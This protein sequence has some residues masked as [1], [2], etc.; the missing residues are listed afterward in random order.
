MRKT[1][2]WLGLC[3]ALALLP[4]SVLP[5]LAAPASIPAIPPVQVAQ[6]GQVSGEITDSSGGRLPAATVTLTSVERGFSRTT[7]TD[8]TGRFLF[9]LVSLGTYDITV[10]LPGFQSKRIT[11]NLV[12]A[13]K[14]TVVSTSLSVAAVAETTTVVGD[15]P[16]V[17]A[18]NQTQQTRLRS[19]EFQRLPVGRSYQTLIGQVA[20]VVGTGNVNAHGALT[21]NNQFMSDGVNTSDTVTGGFATNL[22]F[23]SIA[24]VVVRTAG[25]PAE[26]GRSTGAYVDVITK[27]GT[28][29][30]SGSFKTIAINDAWDEPNS[31][32]SE[33]ASADCTF[34]SL[35]RTK[36]DK[37]NKTYS[38]TVG[39]PL[40]VNRAWFFGA[41]EDSRSTTPETQLNARPGIT[42]ENFQQV[43]KILYPNIRGT[44]QLSPGQSV[45]VKYASD[46]FTGI[47]RN[48]Y[49]TRPAEREALTAQ[50]QGGYAV[51]G[52]YTVVLGNQ[53]TA[54]ATA[55]FQAN[56]ITVVPF[57]RTTLD[58]G[59]PYYDLNDNRVY[60]G[61]TFDGYVKRPRTQIGAATTYITNLRGQAHSF[62]IGVDAQYLKSENA[63]RFPNNQVF[64][65]YDFDP[66]ARRFALNDSR[67]DYD[68]APSRSDG[69]QVAVYARDRFQLGARASVELGVRVER[70][71]GKSDVGVPTVDTTDIAPRISASYALTRDSK[72]LVQASYGRFYDGVLQSYSDT[73]ANV[74]Q[75]ENY[76]TYIWNGTDYVFS[77]RSETGANTFAPDTSVTP[78]HM[79]EFTVGVERQFGRTLGT[80]VRYIQ[81]EWNNFIDDVRAFNED[82]TLNRTVRNVDSAS[83]SYKGVE[84]T[85][86]KRFSSRW[87]AAGSY[88]YSETRGNHVDTGDN[89][90]PLEDYTEAICSQTVDPG[91]FGGGTFPCRE[92]QAN[93]GGRPSFDRPHLIKFSGS[94]AREVG[95]VNLVAGLVGS[96]TSK[97]TYQ[98]TRT[99]DVLSPVTGEQFA[100]IAYWYEP[101]GTQRIPGLVDVVDLNLEAA[102]RGPKTSQIG[103][104][105]ET[106]NLFN[107]EEKINVSNTT[108]CESTATTACATAV[109]NFGTATSRGA[110]QAPRT[111][112]A[113]LVVRY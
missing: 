72:T 105:F 59:A 83:R 13:Q 32:K 21:A 6:V 18:T 80:G 96:I 99:V 12:E 110:F 46:P 14:T 23:E 113:T 86:D 79:D 42:P 77:S 95:P 47:V 36:F 44:V 53:W 16:I 51:S 73:F 78:R 29:R 106:F 68:D 35:N 10:A 92:I 22:N 108:W 33:V 43:R 97:L 50:E 63:F 25:V 45:W 27:S 64:Y 93:L 9:S 15:V 56:E 57:E 76:N 58:N 38:V 30:F 39:G 85:F 88:T 71:T 107:N 1:L 100:T 26:Y 67:E 87:A 90:T 101:R 69:T 3:G 104:R 89:F 109:T 8:E 7:T 28:N 84:I 111:Y 24:E 112:R 98:K 82:G 11:G 91:L 102:W 61:A 48:D 94:Y 74:P 19:E 31:T 49:W 41:Y 55:G 17:D 54:E 34:P 103:L 37:V 40:I 66:V 65:G 60:N 2:G 5:V 75:Q 52:Q 62:K 4:T 70:Q 81:R 20:G